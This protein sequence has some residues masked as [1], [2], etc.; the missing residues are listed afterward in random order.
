MFALF[1]VFG[2]S[3]MR[4]HVQARLA[5]LEDIACSRLEVGSPACQK[6][7]FADA[8]ARASLPHVCSKFEFDWMA[9]GH[10]QAVQGHTR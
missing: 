5:L 4:G 3:L 7:A 1:S 8:I 6:S 9:A 10:G 2:S